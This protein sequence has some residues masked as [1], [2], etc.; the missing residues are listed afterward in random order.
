MRHVGFQGCEQGGQG[1]SCHLGESSS[2]LDRDMTSKS[3]FLAVHG[4][5]ANLMGHWTAAS[6]LIA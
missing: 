1:R 3:A 5:W 6:R 4:N 2:G